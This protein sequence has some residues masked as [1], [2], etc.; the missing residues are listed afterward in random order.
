MW[1]SPCAGYS[2]GCVRPRHP[3]CGTLNLV[4]LLAS[5]H[6]VPGRRTFLWI[7]ASF[8]LVC[9]ATVC[10]LLWTPFA[11][12]FLRTTLSSTHL[13]TGRARASFGQGFIVYTFYARLC[14]RIS[15]H[16][17]CCI[18]TPSRTLKITYVIYHQVFS[19]FEPH[20]AV[21]RF[22]KIY[23]VGHIWFLFGAHT[24]VCTLGYLSLIAVQLVSN[25]CTSCTRLLDICLSTAAFISRPFSEFSTVGLCSCL[26]ALQVVTLNFVLSFATSSFCSCWLST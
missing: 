17:V 1:G 11:N 5:T 12:L 13:A 24:I 21:S 3:G 4:K 25:Y 8:P 7:T 22:L 14:L 20:T 26:Q 15:R 23:S 19:F 10:S 18:F 16:T 6:C 9:L 2:W